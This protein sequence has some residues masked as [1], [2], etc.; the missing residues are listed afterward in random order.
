M[1]YEL[2]PDLLTGNTLI[3]SE[4]R[5]LFSAINNLMTDCEKGRGRDSITKTAEFLLNY[6][7]KHFGDEEK[8]QISTNYPAYSTH[9]TFHEGYKKKLGEVVK[10]IEQNGPKITSLGKLN[11]QIAVL[12]SHIRIEDKKMA[13]H[14]K[15][16]SK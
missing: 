13:A 8:L 14:V 15:T 11:G 2:T 6:V 12:V 4:H 9:K 3:D 5:Q 10:E 7:A 16:A 1:K